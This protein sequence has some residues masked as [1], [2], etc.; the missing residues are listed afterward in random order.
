[1]IWETHGGRVVDIMLNDGLILH[2]INYTTFSGADYEFPELAV[3][4][5]VRGYMR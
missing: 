5:A 1:M 4:L 3:N 2:V